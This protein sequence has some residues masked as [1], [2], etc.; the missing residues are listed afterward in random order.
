MPMCLR[1]SKEHMEDK[2]IDK[3]A[4]DSGSQKRKVE[5]K[6]VRKQLKNAD[7]ALEKPKFDIGDAVKISGLPAVGVIVEEVD[8]KGEYLVLYKNKKI[9]VMHTR[10]SIYIGKEQLYPDQYDMDNV[11][12]VME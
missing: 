3:P 2:T 5:A 12:K 10:L 9:R 6:K 8:R 7:K 11:T 1:S 4:Y